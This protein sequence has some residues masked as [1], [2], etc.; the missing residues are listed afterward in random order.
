ML[1]VFFGFSCVSYVQWLF[2][3][4]V[5]GGRWHII[6][7]LAVYTT[8][9]TYTLPSGGLYATCHLSGEPETTIDMFLQFI[10]P[11][12]SSC[13]KVFRCRSAAECPGG[14]PGS[15]SGGLVDTP[16]S[17]CPEGCLVS[18]R[19][20]HKTHRRLEAVTEKHSFFTRIQATRGR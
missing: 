17:S 11:S 3:V 6:P 12:V 16:C 8:Y 10:S 5:K 7:Q 14:A 1:P 15:C 4:P 18:R 20:V 2:L 9:T 13:A 19:N